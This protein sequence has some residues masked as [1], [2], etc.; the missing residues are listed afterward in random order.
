MANKADGTIYINT[1]IDTDGFTAGGKEVEAAARRMAKSV[2]GIGDSAKL[3]LQK[4]TDA[5]VKQNQ[6]LAQ[7]E[8][9]VQSLKDKLK[10]MESQ[11]IPTSEYKNLET[12]MEKL[13]AEFEKL[14]EKQRDLIAS[15]FSEEDAYR[16]VS[17]D[18][19]KVGA[20]MDKVIAKQQQMKDAGTAYVMPDTSKTEQ[21]LA[22][23][24]QRLA[25]MNNTLGSSYES[26][27]QKIASYNAEILNTAKTN[28]QKTF[29]GITSSVKKCA[30][31]FI[32]LNKNMKTANSTTGTS[33]LTI[34]KY[35]LGLRG[36]YALFSKMRSAASDGFKNLAQ[37]SSSTNASISS[38]MS[39]LAQLKNSLATAFSP[40]L[41][42]V[43]PILTSFINL[44]SRA[45]TYVGMFFAALT[46]QKSFT[47]AVAVQEDYAASLG[48]TSS[49][50]KKAQKSLQGYLSGLDEVRKYEEDSDSGDS[51][52]SGGYTGP[53]AGE[54]FE[55][56]PIENSI[57]DLADKAKEIFEKIFTPFRQAWEQEGQKTIE[58]AKYAFNSLG[59]I[60]V[61]VGKSMLEVWTNGT[62]TQMLST[63]LQIAQHLFTIVGNIA[64]RLD[65]AWNTADVGTTIMQ[66]IANAAQAVLDFINRIASATET[67]SEN[68]DFYPLLQAIASL[69]GSLSPLIQTIGSVLGNMYTTIILPMARYLIETALPWITTKISELFSFLSENQWIIEGVGAALLTAFAASKILPLITGIIVGV[70]GLITVLGEAGLM[71]VLS[72]LFPAIESIVTTLGGSLTLAIVAAI[73]AGIL[74]IT[75]WDKV[76]ETALMLWENVLKPFA[77]Y[78]KNGFTEVWE[79]ILNPALEYIFK[80]IVP[81]VISVFEQLWNEVLVPLGEFI[82][83][84]LKPIFEKL[85]AVLKILWE[86]I[87]LPLAEAVGGVFAAA[88]EGIVAILSK[89]VIPVVSNLI[90]VFQ[91]LWNN[92]LS[93]L[94]DF[95]SGTFGPVF[96]TVCGNIGDLIRDIQGIFEGLIEFITGVF[97]LDWETA[98]TGIKD[99]FAN[100]FSGLADIAKIPINAII[101]AFNA[102]LSVV[103]G[104]ISKINS[105]SFKI[106]VPNWVPG[107]GGSWWGFNGFNIPRVGTIP[108]L[109]SGAVIPPNAPF[110]AVLG[111]QK[112]GTNIE[113][114]EDLLRKIVREE[115]SNAGFKGEIKIPITLNGRTLFEAIIDEA[116]LA[117]VQSG[118]NPF[119][120]A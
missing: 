52:S 76:K 60:A 28:L 17:G 22:A 47:K 93:P 85:S 99:I 110:T 13:D 81:S 108:Y 117:R 67:W 63:M 15:G 35:S 100:V 101:G 97:T 83:S 74:L 48:D 25:Q 33:L 84:V 96:E 45:I 88:F 40:I 56:V 95:M 7:Q 42:V 78:I 92:V 91:F 31:A 46:G 73:G 29:S 111:D 6:M 10:G 119:E 3:A 98:W 109:A 62:G 59:E 23:A 2:S 66:N 27:K 5:F 41:S 87:I 39:A 71:G 38:L 55:T 51:G 19:E 89:T 20:A 9:K 44:L 8:Q 116:M 103:N 118:R 102:V 4:Q 21:S 36:L 107:I 24:E 43:A 68:L 64:S 16:M 32:R 12:E 18:L 77:D 86:N 61:S 114:P 58:A 34:L 50:A 104:V 1:A 115:S 37:Y 82:A 54:M 75:N 105:I 26:L 120:M 14:G 70:Q 90:A 72:T 57:S 79:K 113:T 112:H 69:T 49:N 94:I 53:S 11:Q 106:T 80:T 30:A 65:D